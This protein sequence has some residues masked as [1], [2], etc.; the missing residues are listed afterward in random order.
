MA[1][2]TTTDLLVPAT[3]SGLTSVSV[4]PVAGLVEVEGVAGNGA[5]DAEGV[6]RIA[7]GVPGIDPEPDPS[8]FAVITATLNFSIVSRDIFS[9]SFSS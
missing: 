3:G 6:A 7:I 2:E 1:C 5:P 9:L 8:C 4:I